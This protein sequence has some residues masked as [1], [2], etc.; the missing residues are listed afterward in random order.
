MICDVSFFSLTI[1]NNFS[2]AGIDTVGHIVLTLTSHTN[3][4][5]AH[6]TRA[7]RTMRILTFLVFITRCL[8]IS[9]QGAPH[10]ETDGA[11]KV[12]DQ[13]NLDG[14]CK[15][16]DFHYDTCSI[17]P[18][19]S[20][21]SSTSANTLVQQIPRQNA[22]RKFSPTTWRTEIIGPVMH[23]RR[24]SSSSLQF[25][26]RRLAGEY[27]YDRLHRRTRLYLQSSR[28]RLSWLGCADLLGKL[29]M[30]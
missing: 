24:M 26:C 27:Q 20:Y 13:I 29:E 14:N 5:Q 8:L 30:S 11:L 28:S 9:A 2:L 25:Q 15:P 4:N 12:C 21:L 18:R 6:D 10:G 23:T 1:D 7:L 17:R 3:N 16:I 22:F 19:S